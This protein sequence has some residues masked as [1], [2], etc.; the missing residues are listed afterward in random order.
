[1][2]LFY[3]PVL[4]L[5]AVFTIYPVISGIQ[6]SFTNWDGYSADR[7]FAGL[8]NYGRLLTDSTFRS[9]FVNTLIYGI[10]STAI[11]QVLGLGLA[12]ALN[13]R[14]RLRGAVRAVVYL[15]VLISPIIMGVMYYLLFQYNFGAL[16]TVIEAFGGEKVVWFEKG[17]TAVAIVVIVNSLQYVGVSMIIYLAGLQSIPEDLTQAASL[18]GASGWK[19]FWH[20]TLPLLQPAFATSIVLNLIGGLK[21][22]DVIKVLTGGGPGYATNSVS[23]YISVVYFNDQSAGYASAMGV[24]LFVV[25][26]LCTLALNALLNRTRV[27]M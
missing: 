16:N 22:Y 11:Q 26:A 7:A 23:T 15:P 12:L 21:L 17:S 20:I 10:G 5:L 14:F 1:M 19:L 13:R 8:E 27:E 25:I 6:L 9:V 4:A 24:A 2:N 3:V 18:D